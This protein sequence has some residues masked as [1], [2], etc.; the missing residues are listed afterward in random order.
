MGRQHEH[1][2]RSVECRPA[3]KRAADGKRHI[4]KD[5]TVST[6]LPVS[7]APLAEEV[8]LLRAFLSAEIA[9]LL[10]EDATDTQ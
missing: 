4:L 2:S 9:A 1:I 7:I 10:D 3:S 8:A 6:D 5:L